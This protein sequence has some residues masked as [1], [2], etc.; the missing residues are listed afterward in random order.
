VIS[1]SPPA[2]ILFVTRPSRGGIR[3]HLLTLINFLTGHDYEVI[4]AC[5]D[6]DRAL[7]DLQ[8]PK[9]KVFPMKICGGLDPRRDLRVALE[10]KDLIGE[11]DP[12]IVHAHSY[13]A[14]FLCLPAAWRLHGSG[15]RPYF[16]CTF[17]NPVRRRPGIAKNALSRWALSTTGKIMD[18]IIVVS[19]ALQNEAGTL[20]QIPEEKITCIYNG[21]DLPKFSKAP[22]SELIRYRLGITRF[23]FVVGTVARLI[24]E[25]GLQYLIEAASLLQK[26]P[27]KICFVVV[28]DGPYRAFLEGF[29]KA[30]HVQDI[31]F[32]TG[33]RPDVEEILSC[34]DLFIL[35]SV[36]EALSMAILEAMAAGIPVI[37]SAVGGVPEVVTRDVGILVPSANPEKLAESISYLLSHPRLRQ[38]LG[39]NGRERVEKYFSLP[40]MTGRYHQFYSRLIDPSTE[41]DLLQKG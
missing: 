36:E 21:I 38:K 2:R 24:P 8:L 35:P 27:G 37:A 26:E 33:F 4:L 17:H 22:D 29:A 7:R 32:F 30:K 9:F 28:G 12:V 40:E 39:E 14:G 19:Q 6:E 13:K 16:I 25:K 1:L 34:F 11:L 15:R 18:Y 10:I 23:K 5:P 31:I 20:L 41:E 3:K